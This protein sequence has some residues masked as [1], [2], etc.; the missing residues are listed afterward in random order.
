MRVCV[1]DIGSN[2]VKASIYKILGKSRKIE[3]AYKGTKEMLITYINSK[4]EMTEEGVVKLSSAVENLIDFSKEYECDAVYAFATASLRKAK[5]SKVIKERIFNDY[6][7]Q[8]EVLTES[9]EAICS[10][11][12]LLSDPETSEVQNGI[13][14]DM[15]GG[16]TEVVLFENGK[17]P[18]IKS[19]GFGCLSLL[20]QFTVFKSNHRDISSFV[21]NELNSVSFVKNL[22][23]PVFLIGG[24]AR[25]VS[26]VA[27]IYKG[28]K[29]PLR[30]DGSDFKYIYESSD[31]A[32]FIALL[33]RVIPDRSQTVISGALAYYEI[34]NFIKPEKIFVSDSGVR[35]GYL[36]K[37]L[38]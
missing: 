10:L 26:K 28:E 31:E 38:P 17:E 36:E 7:I 29:K 1:I 19:L 32:E 13:M 5:N 22:G 27:N 12:G 14:I 9:E 35:D 33:N 2:T 24:T 34:I 11:K 4:G 21:K 20:S 23:Y 25:A 3:L 15:G 6:G 30:S 16:S 8:I 18:V 37:I